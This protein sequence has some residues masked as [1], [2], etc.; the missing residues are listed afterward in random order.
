LVAVAPTQL[1]DAEAFTLTDGIHPP[2]TFEFDF[3]PNPGVVAPGHLRIAVGPALVD[4]PAVADA[5]RDAVNTV[6]RAL[7]IRASTDAGAVLLTHD[8]PGALGNQSITETVA[9][10]AFAALGLGGGRARDC[11]QGIGCAS[12]DDCAWGLTCQPAA[13]GS[14]SCQQ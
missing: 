10:P 6:G 12:T 11:G 4:A 5:I 7:S 13:T 3:D 14:L 8:L 1:L 2:T 9:D